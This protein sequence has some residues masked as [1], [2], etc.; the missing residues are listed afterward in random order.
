MTENTEDR[1]ETLATELT[2]VAKQTYASTKQLQD[3]REKL[4]ELESIHGVDPKYYSKT[5]AQPIQLL[6]KKDRIH[7][8]EDNDTWVR[9]LPRSYMMEACGFTWQVR[10]R[11][12]WR[13]FTWPIR[14]R[15]FTPK[16]YI[17]ESFDD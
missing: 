2:E 13:E 12:W 6:S 7:R 10:V 11:I 5:G 3:F 9:S 8:L 16:P 15:L 1:A 14:Q 17:S 4:N